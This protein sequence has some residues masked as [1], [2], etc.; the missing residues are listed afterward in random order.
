MN[1]KKIEWTFLGIEYLQELPGTGII[2]P[3]I[4]I[5]QII[6]SFQSVKD[7]FTMWGSEEHHHN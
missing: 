3:Q 7:S 6:Y 1:G 2:I 5:P 4:I